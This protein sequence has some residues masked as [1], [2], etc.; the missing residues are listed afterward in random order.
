MHKGFLAVGALLGGI[1]VALGA[2]GAHGLKR[3]VSAGYGK[4][5]SN[6]RSISNVSW[7]GPDRCCYHI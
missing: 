6:R 4:H 5:L 3:I 7:I 2:F 1:A